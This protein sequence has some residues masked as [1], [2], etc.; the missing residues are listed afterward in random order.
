[1]TE[2]DRD[3][4]E[5]GGGWDDTSY[6]PPLKGKR[7]KKKERDQRPQ[8][9]EKRQRVTESDRDHREEGRDQRITGKSDRE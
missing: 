6:L 7:G 1:V 8:G 5:E 4:R 3:H 9:R 2:R